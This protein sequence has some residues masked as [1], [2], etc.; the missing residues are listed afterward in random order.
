MTMKQTKINI[1][2][3]VDT[4]DNTKMSLLAMPSGVECPKDLAEKTVREFFGNDVCDNDPD[5]LD[6]I[7]DAIC[8]D[9]QYD[10]DEYTFFWDDITMYEP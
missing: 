7:T 10:A 4:E 9:V 6:E 1:L 8:K 3:A 2:Y 5:F